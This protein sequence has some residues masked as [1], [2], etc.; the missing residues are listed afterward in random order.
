MSKL[1]IALI[2]GLLPV[3]YWILRRWFTII[4]R[5][6]IILR[7][8]RDVQDK[9]MGLTPGTP[10]FNRSYDRLLRLYREKR[11]LGQF[12]GSRRGRK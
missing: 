11:D 2:T 10:A 3:A 5:E 12:T 6:R 8:I 9:L 7:E 4:R 1:V